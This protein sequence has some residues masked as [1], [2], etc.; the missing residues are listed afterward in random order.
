[1]QMRVT[2]YIDVYGAPSD[3]VLTQIFVCNPLDDNG[4]WEKPLTLASRS[5][6]VVFF[7]MVLTIG[8]GFC[9]P[10]AFL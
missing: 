3:L 7:P 10:V 6:V 8:H 4:V 5:V 2:V 1:M 9:F